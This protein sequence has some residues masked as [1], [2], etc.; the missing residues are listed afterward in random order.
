MGGLYHFT[1]DEAYVNQDAACL[2]EAKNAAKKP[3]P[4]EDNVKDGL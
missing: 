1:L 2:V 3:L 4:S